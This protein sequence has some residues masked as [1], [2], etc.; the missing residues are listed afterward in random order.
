[1]YLSTKRRIPDFNRLLKVLKCKKTDIPVLF[2][3][4]M[5][6]TVYD[7]LTENEKLPEDSQIRDRVKMILSFRNA[8]YDY[9]TFLPPD[10]MEWK[11]L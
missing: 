2:E 11:N 5:N 7:L 8:G 1:M 6:N 9:A 3:Y 10:L 4:Y